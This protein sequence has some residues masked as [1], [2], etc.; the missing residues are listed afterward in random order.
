MKEVRKNQ[1]HVSE[2]KEVWLLSS[3]FFA[4]AVLLV[5]FAMN[6]QTALLLRVY[7]IEHSW[8]MFGIVFPNY[9]GGNWTVFRTLLVYGI[10]PF[11]WMLAG[12]IAA[13]HLRR[14]RWIHWKKRLFITYLLFVM[15]MQFPAGL[16]S[17]IFIFNETGFAFNTLL[18]NIFL[19]AF[20][21]LFAMAIFVIFR[22]FWVYLFLKTAYSR[23][24]LEDF[25]DMKLYLRLV[26]I[27]PWFIISLILIPLAVWTHFFTPAIMLAA[28]GF[29]VLPVF[30]AYVPLHKPRI[31]IPYKRR[32]LF[33][34]FG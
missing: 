28:M 17:G 5:R 14:A 18:T 2:A 23:K 10:I 8:L 27:Y 3:L 31:T 6:A 7:D 12:I 11:I 29:V 33:T 19:R 34:E 1:D 24:W 4:I 9:A 30:N 16:I 26:F 21:A 32:I 15:V 13:R 22:G 20:A 25:S